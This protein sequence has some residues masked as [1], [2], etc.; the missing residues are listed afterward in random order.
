MPCDAPLLLP[1]LPNTIDACPLKMPGVY[2]SDGRKARTDGISAHFAFAS[3][4]VVR[5]YFKYLVLI[6]T[7]ILNSFLIFVCMRHTFL[8]GRGVYVCVCV[9]HAYVWKLKGDIN[10]RFSVS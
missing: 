2:H 6:C 10:Y 4:R 5:I 3:L 7:F 9:A 8:V 1:C